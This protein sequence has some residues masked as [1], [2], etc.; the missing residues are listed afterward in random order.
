MIKKLS[1]LLKNK[2]SIPIIS[3]IILAAFILGY[4]MMAPFLGFYQDDWH[5]I[6]YGYTRGPEGLI[7]LT[8]YDG[9][10]NSAWPY[11]IGFSILGFKPSYWQF[12]SLLF[13]WLTVV[14]I[15]YCLYRIWPN[16]L[17][18]TLTATLFFA[19]YPLYTLQPQAVVYFEVWISFTL[20]GLS[21]LFMI[22]ALKQR[23]RFWLYTG[24]A[25]V[26]KIAHLFT[27]EYV[28]GVELARPLLI[29]VVLGSEVSLSTIQKIKKTF[30]LWM[31]YLLLFIGYATWRV[32]LYHSP[33]RPS[34]GLLFNLF[35]RPGE[36]LAGLLLSAT[37]DLILILFS[38]WFKILDPSM[39]D[40]KIV[41]NYVFLTF[42]LVSFIGFWIIFARLQE[43]KTLNIDDE[44][45]WFKEAFTIGTGVLILGLIP[46]TTN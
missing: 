45:K 18:E 31:P 29:W 27:S 42:I 11:I 17:L 36:T 19:F 26:I 23:R 10:P 4:G 37:P 44:N 24:I 3:I 1:Y 8:N 34:A 9:H 30:W 15:W 25:I 35:N 40:F 20:L 2:S 39:F 43:S 33:A 21:F 22:E 5:F 16:R 32:F 7:E 12:L 13:R 14:V 38:S 6:Y 46:S 28:S 41:Y